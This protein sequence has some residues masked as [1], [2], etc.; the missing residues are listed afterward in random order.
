MRGFV[1][2]MPG[3]SGNLY[4][5]HQGFSLM[6]GV[7]LVAYGAHAILF[8]RSKYIGP[9]DELPVLILHTTVSAIAVVMSALFFF[10]IP[11]ILTTLALVAFGIALALVWQEVRWSSGRRLR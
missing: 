9:S 4:Q 6:M 1:I 7:L 3:R 11:L 10:L 2:D 5:Y 8:V